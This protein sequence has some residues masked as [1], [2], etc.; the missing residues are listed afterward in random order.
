MNKTILL[1]ALLLL[2]ACNKDGVILETGKPVITFDNPTGVYAVEA[3]HELTI[4]ASVKHG[5]SSMTWMLDGTAV[6]HAPAY[7]AVWERTGGHTLTF[8]ASNDAGEASGQVV[9][10][11]LD[12]DDYALFRP[13][14]AGHS[15]QQKRI[16]EYTPAPGQFINETGI[17][18]MTGNETTPEKAVAWAEKRL[19]KEYFVSLGG[20][21]GYIVAGFDHSIP[22]RESGYDFA[23]LSNTIDTSSEPGV[24]WVMQDTNA[25]G[26]PDDTWYEL[27]GSATAEQVSREYSITYNRP[28][29]TGA[30]VQ[31]VDSEGAQGTVD[32]VPG[33]HK[34]DSYYPAWITAESYTLHGTRLAANNIQNPV[35]GEWS[36]RPYGWGYVDNLGSDAI[37]G[38]TPRNGFR[39]ENA[40]RADGTPAELRFVDFIK[41]QSGVNAQSGQLGELSTEVCG[42][43]DLSLPK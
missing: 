19:E 30:G 6:G 10:V 32:Y 18:G 42:F 22:A 16:F 28:T 31:W 40:I 36:N 33:F 38:G 26:E 8:S 15:A 1:A 21:G 5:G 20:F 23:I 43:E 9:V 2:G 11:V 3:G 27:R 34:Q 25:N 14:R 41:V 35:T 4:S 12:A 29:Q 7:T 37:E 13:A 17:G 24:V 39:I